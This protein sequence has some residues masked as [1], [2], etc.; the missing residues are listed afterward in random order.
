MHE[1]A[2]YTGPARL[3]RLICTIVQS[4]QR[5]TSPHDLGVLLKRAR[6]AAD[7]RQRDAAELCGVSERFLVQLEQGKPGARLELVLKVCHGLGISLEARIAGASDPPG[8][9]RVRVRRR[10]GA[11]E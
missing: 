8:L 7:L 5:V 11:H 3:A 9:P 2:N 4:G 10:A 6:I 1:C